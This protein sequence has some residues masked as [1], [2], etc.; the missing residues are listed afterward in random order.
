MKILF[1]DIRSEKGQK[2]YSYPFSALHIISFIRTKY[3]NIEYDIYEYFPESISEIKNVIT[4]DK[5]DVF[6]F[7]TYL[8]NMQTNLKIIKEINELNY[9]KIIIGGRNVN[10]FEEFTLEH[11]KTFKNLKIDF[12]VRGPAES[13]IIDIFDFLNGYQ[14]VS[15]IKNIVYYDD[16]KYRKNFCDKKS[17]FSYFSY[18]NQNKDIIEYTL[19]NK[20][21]NSIE[22]FYEFLKGCPFKCSF[23]AY[24]NESNSKETNNFDLVKK[25][26]FYL[27]QRAKKSNINNIL[28][29]VMDA[30]FGIYNDY[31]FK[32]LR[33]FNAL[34]KVFKVKISLIIS[35]YKNISSKNL[36][37]FNYIIDKN[38]YGLYY[39]AIQSFSSKILK[40]NKRQFNVN[41]EEITNKIISTRKNPG[42]VFELVLGLNEQ[43]KQ[44]FIDDLRKIHQ[45][46]YK[47]D[48]YINLVVYN[49]YLFPD[50]EIKEMFTSLETNF[51]KN[52][53]YYVGRYQKNEY[54]EDEEKEILISN[55]FMNKHQLLTVRSFLMF[56]IFFN[57]LF[58]NISRNLSFDE[59][60]KFY[61]SFFIK[62]KNLKKRL[63]FLMK[64]IF[65][66]KKEKNDY[67]N[68]K[69]I[70]YVYHEIYL[71]L[72]SYFN[73]KYNNNIIMDIANSFMTLIPIRRNE[74]Y[75]INKKKKIFENILK[76]I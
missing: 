54:F 42:F 46:M 64:K 40:A 34:Q 69:E 24:S 19:K 6:L 20:N 23:C 61:K 59:L 47:K 37:M 57:N 3:P 12:F 75:L 48:V 67:L 15:K 22:Y 53:I 25:D 38:F 14:D 30:N 55:N 13:C 28:F 62:N 33:F 39:F 5:Y 31:Y 68:T 35:I 9:G 50:I 52:T 56:Y 71:L 1:F 36:E 58:T 51:I 45:I 2:I 4:K 43:T 26:L 29:F 18:Y 49:L 72:C 65:W 10:F 74:F 44:Y 41:F 17:N 73:V 27:I 21:I 66:D 8:W 76:I 7:S 16:Y 60:I 32:I 70:I 11:L 63:N